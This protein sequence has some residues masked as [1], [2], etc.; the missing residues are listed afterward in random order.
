VRTLK[1]MKLRYP[2]VD[3]HQKEALQ[4][5]RQTLLAEKD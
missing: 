2:E 5:A 3:D 1:G 4:K